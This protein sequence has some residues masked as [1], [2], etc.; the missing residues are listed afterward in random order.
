MIRLAKAAIH[1]TFA[2]VNDFGFV[3]PHVAKTFIMY[4][5]NEIRQGYSQSRSCTCLF[6]IFYRH[7]LFFFFG[8]L[9]KLVLGSLGYV[10]MPDLKA[11]I[12]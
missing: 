1:F 12:F 9:D 10:N 7:P 11:K 8:Y 5:R 3:L 6:A 4:R 2:I